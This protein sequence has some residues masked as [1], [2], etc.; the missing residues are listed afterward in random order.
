MQVGLET[1]VYELETLMYELVQIDLVFYDDELVVMVFG[2]VVVHCCC[3]TLNFWGG[4]LLLGDQYG[5]V[6]Q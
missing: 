6:D 5:V 1:L 2:T 4:Q 3:G